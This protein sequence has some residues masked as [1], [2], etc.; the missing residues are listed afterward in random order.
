MKEKEKSL[1]GYLVARA[2][3]KDRVAMGHLVTLCGP[4]FLAH[5][6]RL[7]GEPE[8][9]HDIVQD[10]W[11]DIFKGLR[12]L[13]DLNAFLPWAYRI[14]TRRV[15]RTIKIRQK[16]RAFTQEYKNQPTPQ[17]G[18]PEIEND[19]ISVLRL[20]M[21]RLPAA[22][23]ATVSLFYL[24]EMRIAEVA[25]ALDVPV[26]TVKTRLMTARNSLRA[27]LEGKENG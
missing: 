7:I 22:Q 26:G 23:R 27:I 25:V 15:A 11:I 14:V 2:H 3:L 1:I 9:A 18:E 16:D 12:G 17:A 6:T 10:A 21:A 24:Q 20:A 13:R 5:A 19:H 4:R 8:I